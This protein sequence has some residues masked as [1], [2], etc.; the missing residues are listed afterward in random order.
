MKS[1]FPSKILNDNHDNDNHDM[2]PLIIFFCASVFFSKNIIIFAIENSEVTPSRHKKRMNSFC[3]ALDFF[4]T[5]TLP[6][7]LRLGIK[8]E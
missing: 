5:L 7:L 2:H 4:V 8:K 3:S 1:P 6:K